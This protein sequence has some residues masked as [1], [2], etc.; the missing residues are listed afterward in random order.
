M[1]AKPRETVALDETVIKVNGRRF[2]LYAA[3]DVERKELV[4]MRVYAA[5]NYL[6]TMDFLRNVLKYCK[7]K[8]VFITDEGVV[9][10]RLP[11]PRLRA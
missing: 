1:K 2:Y 3:L 9:Q 7:G 4:W 6:T 10:R 8:P 11:A 5:R